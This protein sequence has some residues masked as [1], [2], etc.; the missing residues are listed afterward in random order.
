MTISVQLVICLFLNVFIKVKPLYHHFDR[1]EIYSECFP[2]WLLKH[3]KI[4]VAAFKQLN[5]LD[6]LKYSMRT[7]CR[8]SKQQIT[9]VSI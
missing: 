7:N 2:A 4:H 8:R 9:T 5:W 6:G 3:G 1:S